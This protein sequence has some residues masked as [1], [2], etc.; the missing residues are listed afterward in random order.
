MKIGFLGGTFNPIHLGHIRMAIEVYGKCALDS[1]HFVP[2]YKP[3]HKDNSNIISFS[4]RIDIIDIALEE[5]GLKNKF[6]IS[7]HEN[8]LKTPSY[9]YFSLEKWKEEHKIKPYFIVGLEDFLRIDTWHNALELPTL[10]HFIVVKRA[11]YSIKDFHETI[12]NLWKEK[13]KKTS[14]TTYLISD[15]IVEYIETTRLDISS[16]KIRKNI[17]TNKSTLCLLPLWADA[18]IRRNKNILDIWKKDLE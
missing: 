6:K 1:I 18:Y 17:T 16:S 13:A 5:C 8:L 10:A 11:N 3:V 14:D 4:T 7:R 12:T 9:T 2:A 15:S